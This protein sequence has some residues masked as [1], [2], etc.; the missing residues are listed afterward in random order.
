MGRARSVQQNLIDGSARRSAEGGCVTKRVG[1]A[2][3][4]IVNKSNPWTARQVALS[5]G[6]CRF[7]TQAKT[8]MLSGLAAVVTTVPS[9]RKAERPAGRMVATPE[10][11]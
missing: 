9:H 10:M 7:Y 1:D 4:S 5:G 8:R 6:F 2:W 11:T 3:I